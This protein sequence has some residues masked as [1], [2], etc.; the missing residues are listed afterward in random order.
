M[1]APISSDSKNDAHVA[2]DPRL[3]NGKIDGEKSREYYEVARDNRK[4]KARERHPETRLIQRTILRNAWGDR[5]VSSSY[6][7]FCAVC[8]RAINAYGEERRK[9]K[10]KRYTSANVF[11]AALRDTNR[12]CARYVNADGCLK[13][14]NNNER[15]VPV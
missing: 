14:S 15:M 9:K 1:T 4:E 5:K 13:W 3:I 11:V 12:L 8:D 2:S 10:D 7:V 6:Y